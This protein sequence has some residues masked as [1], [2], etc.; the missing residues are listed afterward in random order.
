MNANNEINPNVINDCLSVSEGN[1]DS[2]NHDVFI[3]APGLVDTTANITSAILSALGVPILGTVVKLYSKL[4]G[5]LWGSIPGQDPWKELMDRVEILINQK[6][7]EYARSKALAELEGLQNVMKSYVDALESWQNNSRNSQTRLLVQQRFVAADSHFKKAMPS[8]AI[9]NYEVSLLP[10]YA[11]AANL[12]LLLLRDSQ[13]FAK[14]W[15]MPQ[16][17]V[18]LFYKEQ[19]DSIEKYSDHCV[20]WYHTGLNQLKDKGSTAKNWVDYNRYRREMTLA[21]LDIVALLPNYDVHMYPITVHAEL[22]RE[23][24]TD[25]AGS[26]IPYTGNFREVLSWHEMS[27]A[28]ALPGFNKMESLI[29]KPSQFTTLYNIKMYTRKREIDKY[30]YYYYWTGHKLERE[31]IQASDQALII[32]TNNGEITSEE[33][34]F[35]FAPSTPIYKVNCNYVGRY[36]NSLAGVNQVEFHYLTSDGY[37]KKKEYTKKIVVFSPSQRM[38]DSEKELKN[39]RLS[40]VNSFDLIWRGNNTKGGTIPI[41]GWTHSSVAPKNT[42]YPDKITQIS[43]VKSEKYLTSEVIKGPGYTGGDLVRGS[44]SMGLI[45]LFRLNSNKYPD[46]YRIRIRYAADKDGIL[47]M[48]ASNS[49][50]IQI[51]FKATMK[52]DADFKY[53]SFQ[54]VETTISFSFLNKFVLFEAHEGLY[55]DKIEFIPINEN[56]ERK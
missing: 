43:A 23:I 33:N 22:T 39:H 35:Y 17:E 38:F 56:V 28:Y 47:S 55:L 7:T 34:E 14:D 13:I 48:M 32:K 51:P 8:F 20:E 4:F 31:L 1:R 2:L 54:Y 21:V 30:E 12:H 16:N 24:Y 26:Y 46:Y 25:P 11:Q 37:K 3:S 45:P 40:Y 19:L 44:S 42:I 9:K 5:F 10:V 50:N 29:P 18:D 53:N 36:E 49:H 6:L 52:K 27:K 41:L 15:G